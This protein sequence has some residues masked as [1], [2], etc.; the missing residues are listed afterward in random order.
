LYIWY[1]VPGF[2]GCEHQKEID[3]FDEIVKKDG[4]KFS[5]I[6]YQKLISNL[7]KNYYEGNEKYIDYI[8]DRYL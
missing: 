5:A 2:E 3:E 6:S 4:I 8:T 7:A 1:D